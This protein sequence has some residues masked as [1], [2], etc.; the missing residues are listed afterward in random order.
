MAEW[1]E[2]VLM[3][4][5]GYLIVYALVWKTLKSVLHGYKLRVLHK[6]L[7]SYFTRG[8]LKKATHHYISTKGRNTPPPNQPNPTPHRTPGVKL[9]PFFLENAFQQNAETDE[10]PFYMVLAE[11]GMGKTTFLLNLYLKHLFQ[12]FRKQYNVKFLPMGNPALDKEIADIANKEK[13]NTVLLLDGFDDDPMALENPQKRLRDIAAKTDEFRGVVMTGTPQLLP[14]S[15]GGKKVYISPFDPKDIKKYINKKIPTLN[16]KKKHRARQLVKHSPQLMARPLLISYIDKLAETGRRYK[17]NYQVYDELINRWLERESRHCKG[18]E[19]DRFK[20][21][22]YEFSGDVA[23]D[24]YRNRESRKRLG[25]KPAEIETHAEKYRVRPEQLDHDFSLFTRSAEGEYRFT[26]KSILEYFLALELHKNPSFKHR[27]RFEGMEQAKHFYKEIKEKAREYADKFFNGKNLKEDY[28]RV[29]KNDGESIPKRKPGKFRHVEYLN[30]SRRR[31]TDI[32][33]LKEFT[34]LRFLHLEHNRLTRI[35]E[36]N[37]LRKLKS[38][39]MNDNQVTDI[40]PLRELKELIILN[41]ADNRLTDIDD[42]GKLKMLEVLILSNNQITDIG[43]LK[44]MTR[45]WQLNL[46]NNPIPPGQAAAL[47]QLLPRC[48]ILF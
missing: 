20:K 26:H 5:G 22:L 42:L 28:H 10:P 40:K 45:L 29:Q 13:K 24:I 23:V 2:T 30:L 12:W 27:F 6:T 33:L 25:M 41:L 14:P 7:H 47:K 4:A 9:V 31:L 19:R 1:L 8:E 18:K 48:E 43:V 11:P 3:I 39:Y 38:L 17:Y 36:L 16:L 44:N 35:D 21:E 46:E 15:P 34:G 37:R 32:N